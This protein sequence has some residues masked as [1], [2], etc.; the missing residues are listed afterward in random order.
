VDETEVL[1]MSDVLSEGP[2]ATATEI[3]SIAAAKLTPP[4]PDTSEADRG[5]Q[6]LRHLLDR[7]SGDED[8]LAAIG[9]CR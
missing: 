3:V 7:P 5:C 6:Y 2:V 1:R 9:V 4:R 8:R